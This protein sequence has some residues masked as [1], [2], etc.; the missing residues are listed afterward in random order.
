M[1]NAIGGGGSSSERIVSDIHLQIN[2]DVIN[3]MGTASFTGTIVAANT[4]QGSNAYADVAL[5]IDGR[6]VWRTEESVT[7]NTVQPVFFSVDISGANSE[8]IIRTSCVPMNN[9]LALG[10]VDLNTAQQVPNTNS[11]PATPNQSTSS[12]E[13][14]YVFSNIFE[15]HTPKDDA[16]Y[17]V[18]LYNWDTFTNADLRNEYY[19][20]SEYFQFLL[21][22]SSLFNDLGASSTT[23]VISEIHLPINPKKD[24]KDLIWSGLIV[25][26]KSTQGSPAYADIMIFVDGVEK[27]RTSESITANTVAPV[28]YSIDLSDAKYEVII[29]TI[30]TP[31]GD[32]FAIGFV[33]MDLQYK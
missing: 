26:E 14:K 16:V 19:S 13:E 20:G 30:C 28:E 12:R 15:S 6:E 21:K 4:T 32:G 18:G 31:L 9:G 27:W 22:I 24:L 33:W 29:K 7:S 5:L 8:V 23:S 10:F 1:F 17:P 2:S 11:V 3:Q 25:A